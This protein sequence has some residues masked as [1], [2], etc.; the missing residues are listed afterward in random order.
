M[1]IIKRNC[2][3]LSLSLTQ[4]ERESNIETRVRETER[5]W[6]NGEWLGFDFHNLPI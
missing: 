6:N 3:D 2:M 4:R 1:N 5:E